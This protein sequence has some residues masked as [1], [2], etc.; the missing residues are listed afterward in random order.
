MEEAL[1]PLLLL[2]LCRREWDFEELPLIDFLD[3]CS[4]LLED[5]LVRFEDFLI[6]KLL[7]SRRVRERVLGPDADESDS[8]FFKELSIKL[9]S[10]ATFDDTT[11]EL[12]TD[13]EA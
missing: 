10:D 5:A 13:V 3:L 11:A 7:F 4:L 12:D 6:E 1:L 9:G 2:L 8:D